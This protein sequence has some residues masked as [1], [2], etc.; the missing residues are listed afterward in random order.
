MSS[1]KGFTLI[2]LLV[3]IAIIALLLSI[4]MPSLQVAKEM[5][6]GA[7][8]LANLHSLSMGWYTYAEEN[9]DWLVGG[10]TGSTQK[11][12]YSWVDNPQNLTLDAEITA[13]KKGLLFNYMESEKVYHCPGD[14][15]Y[16][17]LPLLR[18]TGVGGYRSYSI[19][20][21]MNGV[22]DGT[23]GPGWG[24]YPHLKRSPIQNPGGKYVFIEEMDGRG[25][26]M[27]SWVIRPT[28]D[29]WVDP[30]AIWHNK[31]STLGFADGHAEK[32]IWVDERTMQ[33]A[34]EQAFYFVTPE[35]KDLEYM[36]RGY[37][38]KSLE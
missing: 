30:L 14:K 17:K 36:Q 9:D 31:R 35:S 2:E 25:Y 33:M 20:G 34:E 3:V 28:G 24:I 16:L 19:A 12:W 4:L 5:G 8:C 21:G 11:P 1:G 23:G 27:G 32:H 22:G 29:E 38:Y 26:N 18:T 10:F 13:I 15:R 6:Q 37:A 7:V